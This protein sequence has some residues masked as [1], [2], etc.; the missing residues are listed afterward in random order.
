[1]LPDRRGNLTLPFFHLRSDGFWHL[2]AKPGKEDVVR[3][4][5]QIRSLF[6][7]RDIITGARLDEDLYELL[8]ASEPRATLRAV[9]IETYSAPELSPRF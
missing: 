5:A 9:L 4:A 8:R 2:M 3:S 6:R 1:M 7:L